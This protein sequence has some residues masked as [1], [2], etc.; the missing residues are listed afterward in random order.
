MV[1][2]S[3]YGAPVES[4]AALVSYSAVPET[5]TYSAPIEEPLFD[6]Y[7]APEAPQQ[8]EYGSKIE[9]EASPAPGEYQ[10]TG[11]VAQLAEDNQSGSVYVQPDSN[12][13]E[14]LFYIY[15]QEPKETS[16]KFQEPLYYSSTN[17]KARARKVRANT[18]DDKKKSQASLKIEIG[19]KEHGFSHDLERS[20]SS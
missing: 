6:G 3:D 2:S 8:P 5:D 10:S 7:E 4:N 9:V 13:E 16:P 14:D 17:L 18:K 1:A 11:N 15:Y 12:A 19:G 20:S